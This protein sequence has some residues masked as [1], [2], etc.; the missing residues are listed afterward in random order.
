MA[1]VADCWGEA[2]SA[3]GHKRKHNACTAEI[4]GCVSGYTYISRV[5]MVAGKLFLHA[6]LL[7]RAICGSCS[8]N[9]PG[10]SP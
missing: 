8:H 1:F 4:G 6:M 3:D 2:D 9:Q 7:M 5:I 10:P